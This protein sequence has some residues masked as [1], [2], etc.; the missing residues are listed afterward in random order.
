MAVDSIRLTPSSTRQCV[1]EDVVSCIPTRM[2]HPAHQDLQSRATLS[3]YPY[4]AGSAVIPGRR[5]FGLMR[6]DGPT[7]VSLHLRINA[8]PFSRHGPPEA[9]TGTVADSTQRQPWPTSSA[10]DFVDIVPCLRERGWAGCSRRSPTSQGSSGRVQE[11]CDAVHHSHGPALPDI[12]PEALNLLSPKKAQDGPNLDPEVE[13]FLLPTPQDHAPQASDMFRGIAAE[14]SQNTDHV[15]VC[16]HL[17]PL[18]RQWFKHFCCIR[19]EKRSRLAVPR[20]PENL[21]Q[22]LPPETVRFRLRHWLRDGCEI[23]RSSVLPTD[24][25]CIA[26]ETPSRR[27]LVSSLDCR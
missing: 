20:Y 7:D 19:N 9:L 10:V 8:R 23:V 27:E 1:Y 6:K 16:S 22:L 14:T 15:R 25:A 17:R 5:L 13:N 12:P 21:A 18:P 11:T 4:V 26:P 3:P 2:L 24:Y